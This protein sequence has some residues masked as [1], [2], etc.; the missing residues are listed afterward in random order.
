M[1]SLDYV[2]EHIDEIEKDTFF[3]RRFTARLLD[4]I[5]ISEYEKF[6]FTYTG[7]NPD[8]QPKEWTEENILKQFKRDVEF[9][10][11]KAT[12][13]RGISS[14]LMTMVCLAWLDV[15]EDKDIDRESYGWYGCDLFK[16]I[17]EKYKFGLVDEDTFDKDF[18]KEW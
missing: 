2:K 6:G 8:K 7:D 15:L 11:E 12:D 5:P 9:G 1:L 17:D 16:A 3:D 18:Y 14:E 10:I 4:F 13:H